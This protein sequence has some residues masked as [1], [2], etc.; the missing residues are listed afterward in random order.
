LASRLFFASG[1]EAYPQGMTD[2]RAIVALKPEPFLSFTF[3]GEA[4]TAGDGVISGA[5]SDPKTYWG[6]V[7]DAQCE[8]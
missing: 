4:T 5:G 7:L 8:D 2:F 6:S 1:S 3:F